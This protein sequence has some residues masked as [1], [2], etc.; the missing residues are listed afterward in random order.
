MNILGLDYATFG[1]HEFDLSQEQLAQ[2]L[3]E[4]KFTWVSSNVLHADGQPFPNVPANVTFTAGNDDGK[5]VRVGLFGLTVSSNPASYVTYRDPVEVAKEQVAAL[6]S[7]VDILDRGHPPQPRGRHPPRPEGPRRST[8]SSA[9]TSTR[10]PRSSGAPT[11]RPSSRPTPTPAPSTST[12]CA[13]T[14]PRRPRRTTR[15]CERIDAR[16]G[17]RPRGA[18]AVDR[19]VQRGLRRLPGPGLRAHRRRWPRPP[20]PSTAVSRASAT[21][22]TRLTDLTAADVHAAAGHGAGHLQQRLHPHRRRPP[23]RRGHRVRH[24]PDAALR[25]HGA[26]RCR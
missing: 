22:P 13:T 20:S 4:S 2:R 12:G 16:A 23:A 18:Q 9:A 1:N 11:S 3:A 19:W 7:Q 6:R 17:R 21:C 24:H 10:T 15:G 26:S 8:S 14:P 5:E 25:R